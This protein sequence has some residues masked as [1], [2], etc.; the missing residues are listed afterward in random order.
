[1]I[2]WSV[3]VSLGFSILKAKYLHVVEYEAKFLIKLVYLG[4]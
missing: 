3:D 4:I 1:M 2:R